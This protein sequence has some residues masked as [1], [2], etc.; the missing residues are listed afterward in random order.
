MLLS[1]HL[2]RAMEP[3][4]ESDCFVLL[5]LPFVPEK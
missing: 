4:A 5:M 3:D 2:L 1:H